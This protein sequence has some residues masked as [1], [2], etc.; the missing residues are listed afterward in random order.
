[1]NAEDLGDLRRRLLGLDRLDGD[2]GRQA[3]RVILARPGH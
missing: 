1:M 2:Y 3:G